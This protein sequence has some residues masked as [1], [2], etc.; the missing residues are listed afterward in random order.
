MLACLWKFVWRVD[1]FL[2]KV[3][4]ILHEKHFDF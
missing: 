1:A 4:L 2:V 3:R